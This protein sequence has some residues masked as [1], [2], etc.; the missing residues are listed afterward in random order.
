MLTQERVR[1]LFRYEDGKLIR[2]VKARGRGKVGEQA[3][4]IGVRGYATTQVDKV[5]YYNH[6]LVFL[7]HHGFLPENEVDHIDRD[8]TNNRIENLR[9]VTRTCN[10][11]NCKMRTANK[12]RVIGVCWDSVNSKWGAAIV[13]DKK[14][15]HLGRYSDLTEAV[16]H[17]LAAEQA[18]GWEG[19]HSST[20]AYL[21]MKGLRA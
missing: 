16:A 8:T 4:S 1:Q 15:V 10:S 13:V 5:L 17:R 9:E 2:R 20:T 21:Y 19:C 12:S 18:E 11:R 14:R 3:G 7:Y 6:R